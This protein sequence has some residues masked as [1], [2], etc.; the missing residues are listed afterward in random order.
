MGVDLGFLYAVVPNKGLPRGDGVPA[1]ASA[2][3]PVLA[4]ALVFQRCPF[5]TIQG[6][7]RND[8]PSTEF[9]LRINLSSGSDVRR[10][11]QVRVDQN[12]NTYVFQPRKDESIKTS[13]HESGQRHLK[14][15]NGPAMF[16]RH[17]DRPKWIRRE[18]PVWEQSFENFSDLLPYNGQSADGIFEI[19]LPTIPYVDTITFAQVSIGRFFDPQG[20]SMDGVTLSTLKQQIFTVPIS[21]SQM[22]LCVRVLRLSH[23][24]DVVS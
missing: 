11:C 23:S 10:F 1:F 7:S 5:V 21:P 4:I 3:L 6:L 8:D 15:G 12:D 19:D 20:W 17:L 22:L 14:I 9:T 2:A 18:Q 16:V 13:Y 24:C